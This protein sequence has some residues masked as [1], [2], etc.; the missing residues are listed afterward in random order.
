MKWKHTIAVLLTS[1]MLLSGLTACGKTGKDTGS[2]TEQTSAA[3]KQ[4]ADVK[5]VDTFA[6]AYNEKDGFDPL[7]CSSSE[8]QILMP[9]CFESL[10][11]LD[12]TFR[13]QPVLCDSMKQENTRSYTLTIR[14]GILFH[15]GQE[16]T[17]ED[18][19]YS[20]NN[21]RLRENSAYQEQL[22]CIS[23][24]KYH[25]DEVHIRLYSPKSERELQAL[26]DVPIFRK[27]S[28]E[29][30]IPDGSG[31]YQIVKTESALSLIPFE[32]WSGGKVGFCSS[33]TLKSVSDSAGAANLMSSGEISMLLQNDAE[34]DPVSGVKYTSSVPTT[35]LHYLGINC[36][37]APLDDEDVRTALSMLMDRSRMVQTCFAGHADA[38]SLPMIT[39]PDGIDAPQYDKTAALELLEDAGIYDR[40]SDGYL[41]ISNSRQFE[42]NIIYNEQYGTKGAV[43]EQY[44][45]TL[46][47]AGI[48]TTVTPLSFEDCQS[49]L[50]RET[51]R[52]YY[53]E[54]EMTA[55]FDLSSI[56][57]DGGDR[58]FG[59]F[60]SS[61][62]QGVLTDLHESA[63]EEYED[64]V[65]DYL[66]CFMEETPI[67][68]IA[69]ER[70]LI[71]SAGKLPEGFDPWPSDMFHGIE[72]WSAS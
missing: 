12:D 32:Q 6:L 46:N 10:Y 29:D 43:L 38:A 65:K 63:P 56:I 15:S 9:L 14:S 53:G 67:L 19:V 55:D 36:D 16:M 50:R 70:N 60:Y 13:P 59:N 1:T 41:D 21:A 23:S 68:P 64:T 49:K 44:A 8:N 52:L 42:L 30:E 22:S 31:P 39:I 51:F 45:S 5:A 17:V 24:V 72:T 35:R 54:Y 47:E 58:N 4:A 20:L 3:V 11:Q 62:M 25:D 61:D 33:I 34:E 7:S 18:V 66:E 28:E 69:F 71:S 26:L 37:W 2:G 57:S 48:R 40:D 27:G